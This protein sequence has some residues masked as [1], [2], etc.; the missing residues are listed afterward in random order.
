MDVR[1]KKEKLWKQEISLVDLTTEEVEELKKS[2]QKDLRLKKQELNRIN[3]DIRAMKSKI[4][5]WSN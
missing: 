2:F 3:K 4:E 5:S 1:E